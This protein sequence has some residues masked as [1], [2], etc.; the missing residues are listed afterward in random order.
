MTYKIEGT[1]SDGFTPPEVPDGA[2]P[3]TIVDLTDPYEE[4]DKFHPGELVT[5]FWVDWELD[6]AGGTE[7][8]RQWLNVPAGMLETPARLNSKSNVYAIMNA[9]GTIDGDGGFTFDLDSWMDAKA[10]VLVQNKVGDDG[11]ERPKIINV[12]PIAKRAPAGKRGLRQRLTD[13]PT[14]RQE[15]ADVA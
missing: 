11:T 15:S 4:D 12:K 2:Y 8:L 14:G 13:D 3:A 9:L 1:V 7:Q 6:L 5:R 10:T